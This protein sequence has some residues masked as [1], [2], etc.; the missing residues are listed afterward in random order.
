MS[1]SL[2]SQSVLSIP[3]CCMNPSSYFT[4]SLPL[5]CRRSCIGGVNRR[6]EQLDGTSTFTPHNLLLLCPYRERHI[7]KWRN[8]LPYLRR[9]HGLW[10]PHLPWDRSAEQTHLISPL[11]SLSWCTHLPSLPLYDGFYSPPAA[12]CTSPCSGLPAILSGPWW[13]P[14]YPTHALRGG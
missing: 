7:C 6:V 4:P 3:T 2:S 9:N 8:P 1:S 13:P 5:R 12:C 11:S 10:S 14:N